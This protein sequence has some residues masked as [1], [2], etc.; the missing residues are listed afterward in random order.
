MRAGNPGKA[1]MMADL[2]AAI[3]KYGVVVPT[4]F[5]DA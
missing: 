3:R 4:T 1:E 5:N 2:Q